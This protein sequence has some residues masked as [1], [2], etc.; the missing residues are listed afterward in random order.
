MAEALCKRLLA[1]RLECSVEELPGRGIRVL[2]AGVSAM[3][4]MPASIEA[5]EVARAYGADLENH[6]SRPLTAEV[7]AGADQVWVMTK[8]HE[9]LLAACFPDCGPRPELLDGE[10]YDVDDPVGCEMDVYQRCAAQIWE[11]LEKRVKTLEL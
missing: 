2:S 5:V 11:H 4:G 10:G 8:S 1:D 3:M 9:R 7:L 6:E